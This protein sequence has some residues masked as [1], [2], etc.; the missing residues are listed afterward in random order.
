M[1]AGP[2]F[3][4]D[5]THDAL[6]LAKAD[7]RATSD[8]FGWSST[9]AS[10]QRE[11][12][13][14]A[15]F[16][17]IADCLVILHQSGPVGITVGLDGTRATSC[18]RHRGQISL[19]PPNH[20]GD[21]TLHAPHDT[22]HVYLRSELFAGKSAD[23]VPMFGVEDPIL[24]HLIGAIGA[25]INRHLPR[26]SLFVDP[27]A[28]AMVDRILQI[29]GRRTLAPEYAGGM[30]ER[31]LRRIRDFVNANMEKDIRL[32]AMAMA[33]GLGASHFVRS[34]KAAVGKTPYQYVLAQRVER[35]KQLLKDKT[36]SLSEIALQCG[37]CHQ[38][39]LTRV[40][41]KFTG[42]TPGYYR[43]KGPNDTSTMLE[44]I[45]PRGERW[46]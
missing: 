32:D 3:A 42:E 37:F 17:P 5:Q 45:R 44:T 10:I 4:A 39:H 26:S 28:H 24:E 33:C 15:R 29:N 7:I 11:R 8:G 38:E 18:Q 21:V 20:G 43:R 2:V 31:Q 46:P 16:S 30:S 25:A 6:R 19:M 36:Q 14:E 40:F 35:A 27:I 12:P 22:I 41:R 1:L 9:Y 13:F 34:F 23:L